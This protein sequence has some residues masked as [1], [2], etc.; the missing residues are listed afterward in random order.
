MSLTH[1]QLIACIRSARH[2]DEVADLAGHGTEDLQQRIRAAR[3]LQELTRYVGPGTDDL[4]AQQLRGLAVAQLRSRH[5]PDLDAWPPAALE[6]YQL[7]CRQQQEHEER[8]GQ[9]VAPWAA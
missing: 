6:Q 3:T 5:G 9:Q 7:M 4:I 8:Y 2:L 1:A